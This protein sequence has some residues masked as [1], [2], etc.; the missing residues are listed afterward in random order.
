MCSKKT[1]SARNKKQRIYVRDNGHCHYCATICLPFTP[2]IQQRAQPTSATLD[3]V[4]TRA[5]GGGN[6]DQN[7]VL[8]CYKCNST[9]GVIP[10]HIFVNQRLWLPEN[11]GKLAEINR[12][13]SRGVHS[14]SVNKKKVWLLE[15]YFEAENEPITVQNWGMFSK[16][17]QIHE[18]MKKAFPDAI[19]NEGDDTGYIGYHFRD[20][21]VLADTSFVA[22]AWDLQ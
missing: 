18:Y 1:I 16:E 6:H 7:L 5:S 15:M 19:R 2:G 20:G 14:M 4:Q 10:Y 17:S 13:F 21:H 11:V 3:H 12:L 22:N 9:R 8:S